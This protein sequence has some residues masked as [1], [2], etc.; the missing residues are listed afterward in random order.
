MVTTGSGLL[1]RT[2]LTGNL[3]LQILKD[4]TYRTIRYHGAHALMDC[5]PGG[6]RDIHMPG[7]LRSKI[8][9]EVSLG[10]RHLV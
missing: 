9:D 6:I 1:G 8:F 5:V 3:H 2:G 7:C 10:I 4:L